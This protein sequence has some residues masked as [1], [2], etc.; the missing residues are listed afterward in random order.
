[1]TQ[2]SSFT[3]TAASIRGEAEILASRGWLVGAAA[4][5]TWRLTMTYEDRCRLLASNH[6]GL[7]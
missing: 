4:R 1:M 5:L 3:T 2:V 6:T 7:S